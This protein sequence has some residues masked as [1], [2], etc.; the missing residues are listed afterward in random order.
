MHRRQFLTSASIAAA[1]FIAAPA[2]AQDGSQAV[3]DAYL[4]EFVDD[5]GELLAVRLRQNA[6][7]QRC[8]AGAE[9]AGEHGNGDL[10]GRIGRGRGI[11]HCLSLFGKWAPRA[12]I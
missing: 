3:V 7:E 8:L 11:G 2:F 5:D 12:E 1:V 10:A 6:V 9:I 4:A